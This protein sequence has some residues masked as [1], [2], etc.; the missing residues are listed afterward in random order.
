M[1]DIRGVSGPVAMVVMVL[2]VV[3][4]VGI[5]WTIALPMVREGVGGENLDAGISIETEGGY[6]YYDEEGVACVQVRRSANQGELIGLDVLFSFEGESYEGRFEE[7]KIPGLNEQSTQCFDLSDFS[8]FGAPERISVV[9]VFRQDNR[10]IVSDI[11][12]SVS[13]AKIRRGS[14]NGGGG[15]G[16]A[17]GLP[18]VDRYGPIL[19]SDCDEYNSGSTLIAQRLTEAGRTYYLENEVSLDPDG[20][21]CFEVGAEGITLDLRGNK[22]SHNDHEAKR[23]IV[24]RGYDRFSVRDGVI[25]RFGEGIYFENSGF[26][27]VENVDFELVGGGAIY[28]QG[29]TEGDFSDILIVGWH[30]E[31]A[32]AI[33][34]S[35]NNNFNNIELIGDE[36]NGVG[37]G[38]YL[39][40]SDGNTFTKIVVAES[41]YGIQCVDSG[42][43][44]DGGENFFAGDNVLG[45]L[46]MD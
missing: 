11:V 27:K 30:S 9:P 46:W 24:V 42:D 25:H 40:R 4:A 35:S 14:Y 7:D 33:I 28:L 19:V 5:V 3:A 34:D 17:S 29:S 12:A 38:A 8:E 18:K 41:S 26:G 1:K 23:A 10:E 39:E 16:G 2:M 37:E 43:N 13:G 44:N 15:G 45:C 6:T 31:P 22:I 20:E 21:S 32:M 36:F